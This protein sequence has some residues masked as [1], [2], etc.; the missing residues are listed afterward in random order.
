MQFYSITD[1][2]FW[3]WMM[4]FVVASFVSLY[5][6]GFLTLKA[7]RMK[8]MHPFLTTCLALT[9]GVILWMVQGYILGYLHARIGTYLYIAIC[10]GIYGYIKLYRR[11]TSEYKKHVLDLWS[12]VLLI[13]GTISQCII[14]FPSGFI[15]KDGI[16]LY[17]LNA[18]DGVMHLGFIASMVRIFPP[19]EP[20]AFPLLLTNYHYW[21]DLFI[22][23]MHRIWGI[24]I[25]L[26]YFQYTP[27]LI[28]F[29]TGILV[30]VLLTLWKAS[31]I[32]KRVSLLFLFFSG[33]A[34]FIVMQILHGRLG[35]SETPAID[36]GPTVFLNTPQA[37]ARLSFIAGLIFLHL[38]LKERKHRY[39]VLLML[40]FAVLF[41]LKIYFGV[42]AAIGLLGVFAFRFMQHVYL[43]F[44]TKKAVELRA[45]LKDIGM[46][47]LLGLGFSI[48]LLA[49]Y[50]PTNKSAGGLYIVPLVWPKLMLGVEKLNWNDWWLRMQV[51]QEAHN[52][53]NIVVLYVLCIL[54]FFVSTYGVRILSLFPSFLRSEHFHGLSA[55]SIFP[56]SSSAHL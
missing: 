18:F 56:E 25:Q 5:I 37:F 19:I 14:M 26:V 48:A 10:I 6:P 45:S 54:V 44:R 53:R 46:D 23:D 4:W 1:I 55:C 11:D 27:V 34:A 17:F 30:Y 52:I 16:R 12:L 15:Y 47:M 35:I 50:L 51:Y 42:F 3:L 9:I 2:G 33:N 41:G 39:G 13:I 8:L 7:I 29:L 36:N 21:S 49:T 22:A 32:V 24:P 38:W 31:N 28:A 40:C 20:G 43:M